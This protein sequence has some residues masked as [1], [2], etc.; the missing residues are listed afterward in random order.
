ME[1]LNKQRNEP[2][3]NK[4]K[5]D[6]THFTTLDNTSDIT[7]GASDFK[8]GDWLELNYATSAAKWKVRGAGITDD[9]ITAS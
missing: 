3:N 4:T 6:N 8:I 7:I 5:R 1:I 9:W 2:K